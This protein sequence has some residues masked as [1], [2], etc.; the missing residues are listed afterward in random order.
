M[1]S[2][3]TYDQNHPEYVSLSAAYL[4]HLMTSA[5]L[6]FLAGLI[7]WLLSF[8]FPALDFGGQSLVVFI[9]AV[10]L[11]GELI[12]VL[13]QRPF[14][15][16]AS[17][18]D[19]GGWGYALP[20]FLVLPCLAGVGAFLISHEAVAGLVCALVFFIVFGVVGLLLKPWKP[21]LSRAE[22]RERYEQTKDMIQAD[23]ADEKY[24]DLE[25]DSAHRDLFKK[26]YYDL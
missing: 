7:Y 17:H 26:R 6:A 16:K 14:I 21:G 2:N 23:C 12:V 15:I 9:S 25:V 1:T 13:L 8:L 24:R 5:L 19:P 10:V 22:I 4:G 18:G 11:G 20:E 3:Q